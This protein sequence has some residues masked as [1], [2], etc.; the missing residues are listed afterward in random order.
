VQGIVPSP[1]QGSIARTGY[2]GSKGDSP[3]GRERKRTE[4]KMSVFLGG[5][6]ILMLFVLAGAVGAEWVKI[7]ESDKTA[8]YVE[9]P[10]KEKVR[11]LAKIEEKS[12]LATVDYIISHDEYDCI[13]RKARTLALT[14]HLKSG[15]IKSIEAKEQSWNDIVPQTYRE[16][17]INYVCKQ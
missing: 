5:A 14:V 6:L 8:I 10:R 7:G 16:T 11:A 1:K 17:V 9:K 13:R 4:M 2:E 15:E 3:K 12:N